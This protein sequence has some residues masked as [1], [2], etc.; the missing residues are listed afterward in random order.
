MSYLVRE[1]AAKPD[2]FSKPFDPI[3]TS[4]DVAPVDVFPFAAADRAVHGTLAGLASGLSPVVAAKAWLDW[5]AHLNMSPGKQ[6]ELLLEASAGALCLGDIICR[7][8][9][10]GGA[11]APATPS[12]RRFAAEAWQNWPY[13]LIHQA[14]LASETWWRSATT[15]VRG[16]SRH[17]E[18]LVSFGVSQMLQALSPANFLPTNPELWHRTAQRG[19]RNLIEGAHNFAADARD[20]LL[21]RRPGNGEFVPGRA[22]ALTPGK[23]I[24]RNH[25]IELIQYEPATPTVFP[26]PVLLVPAWIMKYYILDLRPQNSLIKFLVEQGHTVFAISWKNPTAEHRDLGM[27]DYRRFGIMAALDTIET[28]LPGRKTHACGYCLGGTLLSIAAAT[29][30]RDGDDRLASMSLFAAQTDFTEPGEM[31]LFIDDTALAWLDALMAVEGY[32]DGSRMGGAFQL[33]RADDLLW[34]PFVRRYLLGEADRPNDL[35]AW[36]ADQ[37]RMPYR[38]HTEYL[39]SLFLRNDLSQGRFVVGRRPIALSDI[40]EPI[41]ALGTADDH[42]APWRSVFKIN[43]LA[44]SDITFVLASG[45]HNAGVISEPG[46]HGR[47]YQMMARRGT[48][49]YVDPDTWLSSASRHEGSWWIDWQ[50][51]LAERSG[52][53]IAA[54]VISEALHEAPGTYVLER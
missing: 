6:T 13:N 34:G 46:H 16:V 37:T 43:L 31:Q 25:L 11:A 8:V 24:F 42:V 22:V 3:S 28:L 38:M 40:R 48:D 47:S 1:F 21:G 10:S 9:L 26:E 30:A 18:G 29:M 23:V 50:R 41:F 14:Y 7:T 49:R 2:K 36:N 52:E 17:H 32:L 35:M 45:G 19:C 20:Q 12:D 53:R 27:D 51:W 4:D 5:F 33:L 15:G 54:P 44:R 39:H